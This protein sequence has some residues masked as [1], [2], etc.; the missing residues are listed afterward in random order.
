MRKYC[1]I[2]LIYL[3][4]IS[5]SYKTVYLQNGYTKIAVDEK[6][7][8]NK[9]QF[10]MSIL[11][12]ID[13][14]A[15]YYKAD[16]RDG[17]EVYRFY[18]NGCLNLFFTEKVTGELNEQDF[19]PEINGHRGVFYIKGNRI[20]SDLF[21]RTTGMGAMGILTR[22]LI[23]HRDSLF[24]LD[25]DGGKSWWKDGHTDTFYKKPFPFHF[26]ANW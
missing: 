15:I 22:T 24:V 2:L 16:S 4:P 11:S 3:L 18:N 6:V 21:T 9:A 5:C 8:R 12:D 25:G 20:K 7:Y 23:F 14:N 26:K 10:K 1:I 13:T 17:F 19:N